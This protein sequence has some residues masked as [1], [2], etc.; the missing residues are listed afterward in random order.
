MIL[1]RQRAGGARAGRAPVGPLVEFG[2]STLGSWQP[3]FLQ[4]FSFVVVWAV[5]IHLE[6][7]E[8]KGGTE[9]IEPAVEEIDTMLRDAGLP[10]RTTR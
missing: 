6:S 9:R 3:E 7:S 8:S 10:Q 2:Q 5:L 4:L 1:V